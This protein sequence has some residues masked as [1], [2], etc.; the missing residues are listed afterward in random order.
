MAPIGNDTVQSLQDLVKKLES[1][2]KELEDKL[3]HA[4]GGPAP[5]SAG[6]VRMVLMGPPGAGMNLPFSIVEGVLSS[7]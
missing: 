4:S 6:S 1:R 5:S 7:G 3:H 2:V